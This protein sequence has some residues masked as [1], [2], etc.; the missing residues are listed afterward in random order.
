M[1][2]PVVELAVLIKVDHVVSKLPIVHCDL[3]DLP[4]AHY[5]SSL[6]W[7]GGGDTPIYGLYTYHPIQ[8]GF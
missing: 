4:F 1:Y 8:Y 7:R 2:G 6:G 3:F 5:P